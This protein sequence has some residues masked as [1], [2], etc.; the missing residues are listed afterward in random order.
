[1]TVARGWA[2]GDPRS[3]VALRCRP[4]AGVC[5]SDLSCWRPV[6][7]RSCSS[8]SSTLYVSGGLRAGTGP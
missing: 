3:R 2:R 6:R 8:S 5:G 4:R 7:L 1:M